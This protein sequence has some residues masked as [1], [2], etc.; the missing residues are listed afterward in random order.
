[1]TATHPGPDITGHAARDGPEPARPPAL[2]L[3][4][5]M[6]ASLVHRE[7]GWRLPRYSQLARYY[8]A[9]NSEIEAAVAELTARHLLRRLPDGQL[10]R[11]SPADFLITLD[12]LPALGTR[13]DPM[14]NPLRCTG[15][16]PSRRRPPECVA[17]RLGL[18]A[19][20]RTSVVRCRWAAG[21]QP[22]AVSI[23]Y[24]APWLAGALPRDAP[25]PA[26]PATLLNHPAA[27]GPAATLA[28]PIRAAAVQ[29]HVQAPAP[30]AA[31]VLRLE[32]GEPAL[33]VTVRFDEYA[34]G[35]P[36]ALT[37]AVLRW[38]LFRVVIES[39]QAGAGAAAPGPPAASSRGTVA[40]GPPRPRPQASRAEIS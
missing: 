27:A 8:S 5:R 2:V 1:M 28:E 23:T 34:S 36:A 12:G 35:M 25:G 29:V 16:Y 40:A 31:R 13:L 32:P 20:D 15:W 22:A 19:H 4:E 10:Y 17:Q 21:G 14:G 39:G 9:S 38:D 26:G 30:S 24:L 7:P 18:P 6:A 11:A 37:E 33:S 3:A